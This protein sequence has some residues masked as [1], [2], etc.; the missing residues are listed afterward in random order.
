M[1]QHYLIVACDT[2]DTAEPGS[3]IWQDG[4]TQGRSARTQHPS[5]SW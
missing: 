3:V 2:E 5:E 4:G 1:L